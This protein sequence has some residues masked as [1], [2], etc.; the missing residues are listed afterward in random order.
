MSGRKDHLQVH[1]V[2]Y[3]GIHGYELFHVNDGELICV[4]TSSHE[5]LHEAMD[6]AWH[7]YLVSNGEVCSNNI[8]S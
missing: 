3:I 2:N 7:R 8:Y 5:K 4:C 1:H 6:E